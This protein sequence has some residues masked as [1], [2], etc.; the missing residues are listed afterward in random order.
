MAGINTIKKSFEIFHFTVFAYLFIAVGL[1]AIYIALW[2]LRDCK[3]DCELPSTK[4]ET[5]YTTFMHSTFGVS[6]AIILI[7]LI[8]FA[9]LMLIPSFK[10][11]DLFK[12]FKKQDIKK[13]EDLSTVGYSILALVVLISLGSVG[14]GIYAWFEQD[15]DKDDFE[16][17]LIKD[18][19]KFDT[20][21]NA[22]F[23]LSIGI[24]VLT[25]VYLSIRCKVLDMR[26]K[27]NKK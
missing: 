21:M 6:W 23:G 17:E 20:Y 14:L 3:G 8:M 25:M 27:N 4:E 24:L 13:V 9:C 12:I 26:K 1:S 11:K 15:C 7:G 10:S 16:C 5:K 18:Q 2:A 22:Q 19:D